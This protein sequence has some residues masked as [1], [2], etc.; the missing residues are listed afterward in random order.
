MF[1]SNFMSYPV[2]T[3]GPDTLVPEARKIM[4][5]ASCRHLPVVDES[6]LL[7]GIITDRDIRSALP[8]KVVDQ[9]E[10]TECLHRFETLP[11]KRIMTETVTCLTVEA[12]LDDALIL[13][14]EHKVGALP[15]LDADNRIVGILA[16]N[17]LLKAYKKLFGLGVRG[18]SLIV[19]KDNGKPHPLTRLT[20]IL[21]AREVPFTRLIRTGDNDRDTLIYIRIHTHKLHAIYHALAEAG[22]ETVAPHPISLES[23][24]FLRRE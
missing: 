16:L 19:V 18:S 17:D 5:A 4:S 21:E 23:P 2:R 6:K 11:V 14:E 13:F 8:S 1:V 9:G 10:M 7:L 24:G 22:F 12:T 3:V 15:V 20:E